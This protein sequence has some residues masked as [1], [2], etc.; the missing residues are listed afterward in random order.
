VSCL[1]HQKSP[2]CHVS[3]STADVTHLDW[4]TLIMF[5]ECLP[6]FIYW[7][8]IHVC[9]RP[10]WPRGLRRGS[11][12][13]RLLGSWLRIPPGLL[14]FIW[15]ANVFVPGGRGTTVRHNTQNNTYHTKLQ[16]LSLVSVMCCQVE[17][18][19]T[20]RSLVQ[21][22]PTVCGVSECYRE[23]SIMRRP[24]PTRGCCAIKK[25]TRI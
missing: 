17:V 1:S 11:A 18:S 7:Y 2:V 8:V 4:I 20:G 6:C 25:D 16:Y 24:W 14:L 13:F 10:Q 3:H 12:I 9:S 15:T 19:A 21:R 5:S 22:S 23:A